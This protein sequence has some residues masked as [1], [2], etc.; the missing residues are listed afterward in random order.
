ML[1]KTN[2]PRKD[3]YYHSAA[4]ITNSILVMGGLG[5]S[6]TTAELVPG[7]AVTPV[8]GSVTVTAVC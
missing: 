8:F 5:S 3:R 1:Q 4:R 2:L 7:A 6:K